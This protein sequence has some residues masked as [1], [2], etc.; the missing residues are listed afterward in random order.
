MKRNIPNS[1][2]QVAA[3]LSRGLQLRH[4]R[5]FTMIELVMVLSIISI[6][7]AIALP[8]YSRSILAA[9]ERTLRSDLALLRQ[10]IWRYTTDKQRAPQS[11]DDLR[12]AGYISKIPDDPMTHEPNW[13]VVQEEVL[14]SVDQQESGITDVHSA[15]DATAT[16]GTA[17]STW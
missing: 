2:P 17:Y 16:D 11:L 13:E 9:R 6:L 7:L 10:D 12:S 5:G 3:Q 14:I 4:P 1:I 15:S 8:L